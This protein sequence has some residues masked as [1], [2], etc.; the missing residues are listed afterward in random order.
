MDESFKERH[1]EILEG[2]RAAMA[3]EPRDKALWADIE[4]L[5]ND[6][7]VPGDWTLEARLT[8]QAAQARRA[9]V[10][11]AVTIEETVN[12]FSKRASIEGSRSAH[13]AISSGDGLGREAE[14]RY[15]P[16]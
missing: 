8:I 16:L 15:I 10:A 14:C 5:N 11:A 3:P 4:K 2:A 13:Q 7:Q 12:N 6:E 1:R 9:A